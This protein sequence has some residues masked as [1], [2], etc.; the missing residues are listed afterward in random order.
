MSL[1]VV[2]I[3]KEIGVIKYKKKEVGR[4]ICKNNTVCQIFQNY[5]MVIDPSLI[6]KK[7]NI[8]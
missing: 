8:K 5:V 6:D 2:A 1:K 3:S 7:F 4:I